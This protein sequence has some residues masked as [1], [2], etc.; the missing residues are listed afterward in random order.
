MLIQLAA[1]DAV[2]CLLVPHRVFHL[3]ADLDVIL[4]RGQLTIFQLGEP[5]APVFVDVILV[6]QITRVEFFYECSVATRQI[7][8]LLHFFHAHGC[9]PLG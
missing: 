6:F 9:L 3:L 8:L 4:I 5:V 7:T 1:G 2:A